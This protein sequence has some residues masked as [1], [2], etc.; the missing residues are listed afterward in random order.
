MAEPPL[1][2]EH[3]EEMKRTAEELFATSK[4]LREEAAR[5]ARRAKELRDAVAHRDKKKST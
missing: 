2:K 3:V 4:L 1:S 5:L